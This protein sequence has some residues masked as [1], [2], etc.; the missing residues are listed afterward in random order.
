MNDDKKLELTTKLVLWLQVV[1]WLIV[2]LCLISISKPYKL[3][4]QILFY[5]TNALFA[6]IYILIELSHTVYV[7]LKARRYFRTIATTVGLS[8][9]F[10]VFSG[11][12]GFD[13]A[14]SYSVK[15]HLFLFVSNS[16]MFMLC[17]PYIV[18]PW[19]YRTGS[20]KYI[21]DLNEK[22]KISKI[23]DRNENDA[24]YNLFINNSNHSQI[25]VH[26]RFMCGCMLFAY[27]AVVTTYF[28]VHV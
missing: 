6:A 14:Y 13:A 24:T 17:L 28:S 1:Y 4:V 7:V 8:L 10:S 15:T 18:N 11:T 23:T 3:P 2:I 12:D 22:E 5:V 21:H 16:I 9:F 20:V 26:L 25:V 27:L 19:L